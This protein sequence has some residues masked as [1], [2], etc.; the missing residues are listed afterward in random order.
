M[1]DEHQAPEQSLSELLQIRR[2]KLTALQEAGR[3]PFRETRFDRTASSAEILG[4]FP[5]LSYISRITDILPT[6]SVKI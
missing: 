1:Q 2:D 4:D 6:E 5:Q 3:D